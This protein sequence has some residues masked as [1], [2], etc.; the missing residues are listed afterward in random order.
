MS[1]KTKFTVEYLGN[2]SP[3]YLAGERDIYFGVEYQPKIIYKNE[4]R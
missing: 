1:K 3:E 2:M 4:S